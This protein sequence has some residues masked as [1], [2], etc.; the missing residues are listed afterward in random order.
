[1]G[2][3][4]QTTANELSMRNSD[5]FVQKVDAGLSSEISAIKGAVATSGEEIYLVLD[6]KPVTTIGT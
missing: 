4:K 5:I 1:L 2:L 3:A 6:R